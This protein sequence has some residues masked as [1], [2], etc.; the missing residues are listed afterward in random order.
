MAGVCW[1]RGLPVPMPPLRWEEPRAGMGTLTGGC[2]DHNWG[3]VGT[4]ARE[5]WG[6]CPGWDGDLGQGGMATL[7]RE[8]W[9]P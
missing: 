7:A 1:H 3:R 8:G 5:G 9:G 4:L 2:G 6:P